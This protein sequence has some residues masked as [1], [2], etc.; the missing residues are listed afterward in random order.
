MN[1]AAVFR[2]PVVRSADDT[3]SW[4]QGHCGA[5]GPCRQGLEAWCD[6]WTDV[7]DGGTR[8]S[9]PLRP[10]TPVAT[11][12]SLALAACVLDVVDSWEGTDPV[13]LVVGA[14]G[15]SSDVV[16]LLNLC[17][18][19][20]VAEPHVA[21]PRLTVAPRE[22]LGVLSPSGRADLVVTFEGSLAVCAR[23]VRRSG[24]VATT[25]GSDPEPDLDT[26][27]M[28]ELTILSPRNPQRWLDRM[29]QP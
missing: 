19:Q 20:A 5:C 3:Y 11:P 6:D 14:G 10:L 1:G 4:W 9:E 25:S 15:D 23:W 18:V 27:T 21:G 26:L 2:E 7:G 17:G 16:A 29:G 12:R 22:E 24:A 8:W 13:T 28:R